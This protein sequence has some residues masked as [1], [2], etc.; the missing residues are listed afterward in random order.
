MY[1]RDVVMIEELA[2]ITAFIST[3]P[4]IDKLPQQNLAK[5]IKLISISYIR[6]GESLDAKNN[7]SA[8]LYIIRKGALRY[9]Q[10]D[11]HGS[12]ELLEQ[13]SEGEICA[14]FCQA[15]MLANTRLIADEDCLIYSIDYAL[16]QQCVAQFPAVSEFFSVSSEQ[17]LQTQVNLKADEAK[18]AGSLMD[19][20]IES[21]YSG[22]VHSIEKTASITQ[23]AV[24]MTDNNISSL[25]VL[26]GA[27]LAGIVTDKD[28]RQRCVA[29]GLDV[30]HAVA[31]IM[32]RD[33]MSIETD[34]NAFDALIMMTVKK[35]HHL[36]VMHN[37][38][39]VGIVT[40]TDLLQKEGQDA[41]HLSG[42][43]QR[44]ADVASLIDISK[45][46]P[47]LQQRLAKMGTTA[48]HVGKQVSAI[49]NG[50][51]IRL[52]ELVQQQIGEAPM[53]FAWVVA[54][55]QAR[56]EQLCHTDQDN[57]LILA[58]APSA[59]EQE[60]FDAL[61][62]FVCDGLAQCGYIY[63]PGD[64]MATND[65]WCAPIEQWQGYF[66]RWI[67]EPTPQA[68]LNG[69]VFFDLSFVY[70]DKQLLQQVRQRFLQGTKA[71]T[72]LQSHLSR[73]ALKL[74]PP[75][76]FFRNIVLVSKGEH[77]D[78]LDIKHKGLAAII[79]L[80]RIYALILG[81]DAVNTLERLRKSAGSHILTKA[82][83]DSLIDAFEFLGALRL[84]HQAQQ[85]NVGIA[86]DNFLAP[87]DISKLER[88][89]LKDAFKVIK[90]LQ[91]ARQKD[92]K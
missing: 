47:K 46:L 31:S 78:T 88:E 91:D 69:S 74:K 68:L 62:K 4:P 11:A 84:E 44:A 1:H 72:L 80:A 37:G 18:I 8:Q 67:N 56:H 83:A 12:E 16:F 19:T 55:S 54:G 61:A 25:L 79:E 64:I 43:I 48:D 6:H 86:P 73:N 15:G 40:A 45:L 90:T 21:L 50:I 32:S 35:I 10:Y 7:H 41:V 9:I 81:I 87:K 24:K 57:G 17:R 42:V 14:L 60:W 75:L 71:N 53:A 23:A 66:D 34:K 20:T 77:K 2:D 5:L 26:E 89:H 39:L 92:F 33:I 27:D 30:N 49:T 76:G 3:I 58:R 51:T 85:I 70:G 29:Q 13:Y 52:I 65:K 63:C 28:I 38:L 36:P 59:S 82:S 22:P